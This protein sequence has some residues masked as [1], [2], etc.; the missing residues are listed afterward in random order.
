LALVISDLLIRNQVKSD[1]DRQQ[2]TE[3]GQTT[4]CRW[5]NSHPWFGKLLLKKARD[6]KNNM[7]IES[8]GHLEIKFVTFLNTIFISDEISVVYFSARSK[9]NLRPK[10]EF[11]T[12]K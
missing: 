7:Y 10:N 12:R 4:N 6:R 9:M 1:V 5:A 11:F 3:N 2:W 8:S